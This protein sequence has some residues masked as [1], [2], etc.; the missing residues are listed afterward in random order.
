M[1]SGRFQGRLSATV[2]LLIANCATFLLQCIFYGYPPR[3]HSADLFALSV[4]G[5]RHG[6][7]WQLLTYQFMHAG[8]LHLLFNCWAIYVFGRE[9]EET[10]GVRRFL[11]LYF[12]SGI[13]GGLVQGLAGVLIGGWFAAPVVGASAGAFG[14]VAAFASLYPERPLT[15]LLFFIVPLTIR[16]KYLLL[17]A[18]LLTIF[19]LAF[20]QGNVAHAAHL[21]G[22]LT[23]MFFVRYALHWHWH[24]PQWNVR[25][26]L[27]R[28][29]LVKVMSRPRSDLR[30]HTITQEELSPQDFLSREVDPILEKISAQ[31]IQSLT[32]RERKVLERAREKMGRR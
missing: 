28:R 10:L 3:I 4:E 26:N 17:F 30:A 22:I 21:G 14:L 25:A 8:L 13:V 27:R 2:L 5:L 11:T 32:E 16:A 7:V 6:Y 1:R 9:L 15:L 19:G 23:G 29:P 12:A 24:W 18:G 20:A 31:G